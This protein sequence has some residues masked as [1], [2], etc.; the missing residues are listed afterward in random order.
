MV[1]L[2]GPVGPAQLL[3]CVAMS[4]VQSRRNYL[5]DAVAGCFVGL[6]VGF[7]FHKFGLQILTQQLYYKL[8][9]D[10]RIENEEM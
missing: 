8:G 9:L 6:V 10:M 3:M 1:A 4:R 5:F 7:V 2:G